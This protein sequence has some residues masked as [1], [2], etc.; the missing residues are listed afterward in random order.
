MDPLAAAA[1]ADAIHQR[2]TCKSFSGAPVRRDQLETALELARWAPTHRLTEAWRFYVLEQP[3]VGRLAAF[4]RIDPAFAEERVDP[5][6]STKLQL[7]L[8]RLPTAGAMVVITWVRASDPLINLE[9]HASAAAAAQ[10]LLLACQAMGIA[11]YWSTTR[12]LV[13]PATLHWYGVDTDS[14]SPLGCIWLG[15]ASVMPAAPPRRPL[16]ERVRWL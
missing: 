16:E 9:D 4:L 2:R 3:A 11:S 8:T 13:H 10:N 6:G 1:V 7:L 14:E 15:H 12:A 5:K